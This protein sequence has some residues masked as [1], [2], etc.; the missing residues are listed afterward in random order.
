MPALR[1]GRLFLALF[2]AVALGACNDSTGL[3]NVDIVEDT[4]LLAAPSLAAADTLPSA[5]DVASGG[6]GAEGVGGGRFPERVADVENWD[7]ALRIRDG[8]LRFFP[9]RALGFA[10]G[11]QSRAA[12][13][14]PITG[15]TLEEVRE[16]PASSAFLADSSVQVVQGA[17]YVVRS[18]QVGGCFGPFYSKI[19]PLEVNRA[20][21]TVRVAVATTTP[22]GDQRLFEED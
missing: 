14:R 3:G 12:I 17:V 8:E 22:C 7:V 19:R 13:T 4:V 5:L 6:F 1:A 20:A 2:F 15:R 9:P 10:R 16:A 18:R 11:P 21:G